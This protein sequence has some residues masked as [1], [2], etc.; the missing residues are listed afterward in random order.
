MMRE[1]GREGVSGPQKSSGAVVAPLK[2]R[3]F[4]KEDTI[5]TKI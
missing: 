1:G 3:L 2:M 4:E 5:Y